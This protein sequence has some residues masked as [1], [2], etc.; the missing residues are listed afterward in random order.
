MKKV[1]LVLSC[2]LFSF[3]GLAQ[4]NTAYQESLKEL[5][6]VSGSETSYE[7]IVQQLMASFKQQFPEGS[8]WEAMEQEFTNASIYSLTELLVPVYA[9][10]LTLEDLQ[11]LI[12]FYQ[13]PVGQKFAQKSPLIAQESMPI[14]QQWGMKIGQN[15]QQVLQEKKEQ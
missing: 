6:R 14:A 7:V 4:P 1:I 10:H 13:T 5:F 3:M 15:L 8:N 11:G 2:S 12:A 9:K